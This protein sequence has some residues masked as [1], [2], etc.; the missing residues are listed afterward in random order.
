MRK[1]TFLLVLLATVLTTATAQIG[2][3]KRLWTFPATNHER[4]TEVPEEIFTDFAANYSSDNLTLSNEKVGVYVAE[5]RVHTA[6]NVATTIRYNAGNIRMD[7]SG[8]DILNE[9]GEVVK[10]DYHFGYTGGN[11]SNNTYTL[12]GV[13][14]GDYHLRIFIAAQKEDITPGTSN[15]TKGN[16]SVT[17]AYIYPQAS[18][19]ENKTFY[20]I[21]NVRSNKYANYE[22]AG[23]QFTQKSSTTYGSYWYFAEVEGETN[24][25]EGYKAYRLYNAANTLAVE[26]PSN[27]Y[28]SQNEGVTY[29][30]KIYYVGV[31]NKGDYTN[32]VIRPNNEADASWN[33]AGG[34]GQII[35]VWSYDDPGSI[36]AFEQLYT[37]EEELINQA[38]SLKNNALTSLNDFATNGFYNYI[39]PEQ[40][41][42][43]IAEIEG[44]DISTLEAALTSAISNVFNTTLQSYIDAHKT[45]TPAAGDRFMMKNKGRDG[46]LRAYA[47]DE[48]V[49]C[50]SL[51]DNLF[52]LDLV[53]TL[54]ATD[55]EAQF[56]IYNER[57][58]VY[59]GALS[60]SNNT[61]FQY[62][63]NAD[64]AGV[65]EITSNGA[66]S[67]F[68]AVGQDGNGYLHKSNWNS[69]EIVRWDNGDPSQWILQ[70]APFEL[71]TDKENPICY[72]I[73]SGRIDN[74]NPYFFTF[75]NN[76]IKLYNNKDIVTDNAT[77][78][79]F[80]LDEDKNLQ[81]Y[82]LSDKE[83]PMGYITVNDGAGK[84][85]NNTSTEG[86]AD[87]AY[88]LY[89]GG[90]NARDFN[91]A[92][93][94][95][96]PISSTTTFVSNH[97]GTNNYMGFY[98]NYNDA[99]T[100]VDFEN[101]A[102]VTL[103]RKIETLNEQTGDGL[104]QY[105]AND[106][107]AMPQ[108]V[109]AIECKASQNE[110][111]S[112]A[113]NALNSLSLT[114]N[115]PADGTYMRIQSAKHNTYLSSVNSTS[116]TSRAAFVTDA[117]ASTVFYYK[118]G[119]LLAVNT[120]SYLGYT[121]V[122]DNKPFAYYRPDNAATEVQFTTAATGAAG[123]Y[124]IKYNKNSHGT[125]N[126]WLYGQYKNNAY[127]TDAASDLATTTDKGYDF[128]LVALTDDEV[129]ALPSFEVNVSA[130]GYATMFLDYAANIPTEAEVYVA[131]KAENDYVTLEQVTGVLPA[132]TGVIIKAEEGS[133][134]FTS[135]TSGRA[136]IARNM[137]SGSATQVD[138]TPAENTTYY[139][140]AMG[141][142]G[143][144]LYPDALEGG[145][146]RNNANKAYL[147][148]VTAAGAAQST[149]YR[150]DFEG[151]TNIEEIE[152]ETEKNVI[153][154]LTG[155]RVETPAKGIYIIN[156]KKVLVK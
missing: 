23:A 155:R 39:T 25:P 2:Y 14:A 10:S 16:I 113:L 78:W 117:D 54:V 91:S 143:I 37:T 67:L 123:Q 36:W 85:T 99:G 18:T 110:E 11:H 80:M 134:T 125:Y 150:F 30:A 71:T 153:Y 87:D 128:N 106:A 1:F 103:N 152:S 102:Y 32:F 101:I 105:T 40:Q 148:I 72:A 141:S 139:I 57:L 104:G 60:T 154:D 53:W 33:D 74:G 90:Y 34:N 38:V 20:Y 69:Q 63:A 19:A 44:I 50:P 137:L 51:D 96:K 58:G 68:H 15:D 86:Y 28:M 7:I 83:N 45:A 65:Y 43:A 88:T 3:G 24:I 75:E 122:T 59:L 98:N 147:P 126:R 4:V 62:T 56:K 84:L 22:G 66:Y 132:N 133:Y 82:P 49:K 12:E 46:Y 156:G 145:T 41:T 17:G 140:L 93:F 138:I 136:T 47:A 42:N 151:T 48:T 64:E 107:D 9:N 124:S 97:G 115:M 27:G 26:N 94:A 76:K 79:F 35:G 109:T 149:G 131:T 13:E 70:K 130:A 95:F 127:Y 111:Y 21:K 146:F 89:F 5:I 100:R 73:R 129:A 120:A 108:A 29:P 92:Y 142:K 6:G 119:K 8:V 112:N 135:P 61:A 81:I 55:N 52:A 118:D 121:D 77:H 31:H 116:N 144:G 114:L